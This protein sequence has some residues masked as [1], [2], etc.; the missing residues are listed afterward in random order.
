MKPRKWI[1]NLYSR[2][3]SAKRIVHL[4]GALR[5]ARDENYQFA[6]DIDERDALINWLKLEIKG[7]EVELDNAHRNLATAVS[8]LSRLGDVWHP[9]GLKS[10]LSVYQQQAE[11]KEAS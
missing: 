8:R 5:D 2:K 10:S 7:G 4:E 11:A 1:Y 9:V 3:A 6:R